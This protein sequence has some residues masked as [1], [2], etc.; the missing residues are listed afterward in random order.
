MKSMQAAAKPKEKIEEAPAQAKPFVSIVVPAYNEASIVENNLAKL[1]EYMDSLEKE[2]RWELIV[3]NDGSTDETSE[4]AETFARSRDNVHVLHHSVNFRLGQA[5][6]FAFNNFNGDYVITMDLDL[7]YSPDHIEKMLKTIRETKAKIVIASPYM[8]GGKISNVSWM[9]RTL[10]ALANRFLSLCSKGTVST[11]TSMVRAYD[12]KFLKALDLKAMDVDINYETIYKAQ[13]LG[14]RIV[15]IPGHLDWGYQKSVGKKRKSSIRIFKTILSVLFGGFIF[16]PVM[17]FMLPG[18]GLM[19]LSFYPLTWAFIH[20]IT[21]Y[22]KVPSSVGFFDM[23]LSEAIAAAFHLSPHSFF[24]G[25]ITLMLG[26]QLV[27]LGILALQ[28]MR[29]FEDL[30]HFSTVIHRY[31]QE[32]R[33]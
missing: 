22:K 5:L 7:S 15:E 18:F 1:C 11:V 20:T 12:R 3:V 4:R 17:F 23:R 33:K 2:Y 26:I 9:R 10:S 30:F 8:K 32:N 24:I 6:R 27:S 28:S 31:N 13:L 25:G 16:R 21:F 14:A 29:Y 19:L